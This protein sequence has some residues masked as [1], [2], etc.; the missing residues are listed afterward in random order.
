MGSL[1]YKDAYVACKEHSGTFA[2]SFIGVKDSSYSG[3]IY[4]GDIM[5]KGD[6]LSMSECNKGLVTRSNCQQGYTRVVCTEGK[7]VILNS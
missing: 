2:S 3:Q 7:I 5:C 6:E 4:F 1:D